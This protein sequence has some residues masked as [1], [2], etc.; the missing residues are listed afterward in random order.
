MPLPWKE[1][2]IGDPFFAKRDAFERFGG[3][4][5]PGRSLTPA[6][7]A[8]AAEESLAKPLEIGEELDQRKLQMDIDVLRECVAGLEAELAASTGVPD[9]SEV[10]RIR[11]LISD[12]QV[13]V[14]LVAR[15]HYSRPPVH[16]L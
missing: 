3:R 6:N 13:R 2:T 11:S 8:A 12:T 4:D 16:P 5:Y 14:G 1:W 15:R 7:L 9:A 10:E